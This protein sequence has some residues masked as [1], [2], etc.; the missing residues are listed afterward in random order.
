M[1][2]AVTQKKHYL[3]NYLAEK[4]ALPN[5]KC[6]HKWDFKCTSTNYALKHIFF[7]ARDNNPLVQSLVAMRNVT[8]GSK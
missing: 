6:R 7:N 5:T 1:Q 2:I 8:A 4:R 3:D